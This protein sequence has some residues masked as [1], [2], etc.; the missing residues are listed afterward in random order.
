MNKKEM[1]LNIKTLEMEVRQL[2][3]KLPRLAFENDKLEELD[4]VLSELCDY[5][6]FPNQKAFGGIYAEQAH[7]KEKELKEG[8]YKK[9]G[10]FVNKYKHLTEVFFKLI[11]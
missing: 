5:K 6:S 4:I 1:E 10:G 11:T 2:Q 3:E 9:I 7:K 8:G